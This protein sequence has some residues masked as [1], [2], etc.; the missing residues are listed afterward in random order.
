MLPMFLS[1]YFFVYLL[2]ELRE[3]RFLF[4]VSVVEKTLRELSLS[5]R[6][7]TY[8]EPEEKPHERNLS[9]VK[10]KKKTGSR[11]IFSDGFPLLQSTSVN[12]DA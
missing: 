12:A 9:C 10:R 1:D 5:L 4:S 11:Q 3:I 7:V 8:R 2:P 6:I